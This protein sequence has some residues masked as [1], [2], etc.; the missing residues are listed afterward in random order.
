MQR[1]DFSNKCP[2]HSVLQEMLA[3]DFAKCGSA[4]NTYLLKRHKLFTTLANPKME[5][6]FVQT[7]SVRRGNH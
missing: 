4:T 6:L 5:T 1:W 2:P 3:L 7:S